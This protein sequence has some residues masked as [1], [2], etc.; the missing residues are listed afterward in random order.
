[1][2]RWS[3]VV[4]FSILSAD[5]A[6]AALSAAPSVSAVS[7]VSAAGSACSESCAASVL[8]TE[9]ASGVARMGRLSVCCPPSGVTPAAATARF[10]GSVASAAVSRATSSVVA[11]P[12]E[13]SA[14]RSA[15]DARSVLREAGVFCRSAVAVTAASRA[16][17]TKPLSSRVAAR[18]FRR[19]LELR[20]PSWVT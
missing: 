9:S 15:S 17:L 1:M 3:D 8:T 2:S 5:G 7:A 12:A 11:L 4:T 20:S 6:A 16:W 19:S 18:S 10:V 13:A 14:A